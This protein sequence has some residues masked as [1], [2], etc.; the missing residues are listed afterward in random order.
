MLGE[1]DMLAQS[2]RN[3]PL[4]KWL[5]CPPVDPWVRG[6]NPGGVKTLQYNALIYLRT[7]LVGTD[8]N[9][10]TVSQPHDFEV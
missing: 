10:T 6:S 5:R 9:Y 4:A 8:K 2:Q 7:L 3:I 1:V